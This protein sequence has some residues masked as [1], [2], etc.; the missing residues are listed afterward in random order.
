MKLSFTTNA[1][2]D[3]DRLRAFIESKNPHAARR[4]AAELLDGINNLKTFP[5][6]GLPVARA[7][8]PSQIRDLFVG[9]Y[10][11]R[12]L[13]KGNSIVVLRVWHGRETGKDVDILGHHGS[14]CG[15]RVRNEFEHRAGECRLVAPIGIVTR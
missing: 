6:M 5:H 2:G 4:M 8:D 12:Y 14:K 3:L 13:V 15:S 1:I 11:I 7:P 9:D 10:T